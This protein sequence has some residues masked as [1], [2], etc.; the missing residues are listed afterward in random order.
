MLQAALRPQGTV[1]RAFF[2]DI[3]PRM[4]KIRQERCRSVG[5][6]YGF[7][8]AGRS[9]GQWTLDFESGQVLPRVSEQS[10]ELLVDMPVEDFEDL[11][12]Q[13]LDVSAAVRAGRFRTSGDTRGLAHLAEI[14][15]PDSNNPE[16]GI[17]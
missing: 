17:H 3:C 12:E 10:V 8:L 6:R 7:R 15:H 2:T 16:L 4:L 9:G 1:A 14:F 5:G 11:L 13:K